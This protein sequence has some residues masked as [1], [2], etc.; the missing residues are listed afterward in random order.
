MRAVDWPRSL[1]TP[2]PPPHSPLAPLPSRPPPSPGGYPPTGV[3]RRPLS[4][5]RCRGVCCPRG[6]IAGA[7]PASDSASRAAPQ[8][9]TQ[10]AQGLCR[11]ASRPARGAVAA[12]VQGQHLVR[13][14]RYHGDACCLQPLG[15]VARWQ[16]VRVVNLAVYAVCSW[17]AWAWPFH[18]TQTRARTRHAAL[19][20]PG[21]RSVGHGGASAYGTFL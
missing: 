15:L 18:C 4:R 10:P 9:Y 8:L 12:G 5:A 11:S 21:G 13:A 20:A 16:R 3:R 14:V 19:R 7:S 6:A 2:A 1:W 17:L